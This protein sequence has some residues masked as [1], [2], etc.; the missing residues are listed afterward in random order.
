MGRLTD[1]A[2]ERSGLWRYS[3]CGLLLLAT[4]LNYMDRMTLA[5]LGSTIRA[6]Y[7]LSHANYGGLEEGFGYAFAAG[8]LFFGFL[9]DRL[10]VRWLYPSVLLLWSMAGIATAEAP[11]IGAAIQRLLGPAFDVATDPANH[12]YLG[13]LT[14]RVALGFFE[15]GHWPCAL[16]TTQ[17]ILTRKDRSFGNSILQSGAAIGAVLTPIVIVTMLP[18]PDDSDRYPL[19]TWRLPFVAIG[20]I[21]MMWALPWLALVRGSDL[22]RSRVVP[23]PNNAPTPVAWGGRSLLLMY[24]ALV[25]TVISINLSWQFFRAWLPMFLEEGRSY[26]KQQVQW[27]TAAYYIAADAGCIGVGFLVKWLAGRGWGVHRARVF[28]FGVCAAVTALSV[29]YVFLPPGPL[30]VGLLL[31]VAAA[32]LGLFPNYYSFAQEPSRT[33]Q[34]MVS[35]SLGTIAWIA[36]SRMQKLV[37][38]NIDATRSYATGIMMAGLVPLLGLAAMLLLWPRK[39]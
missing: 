27:L 28:L 1:S 12:A 25:V 30:L 20:V 34:G 5:Q 11:A 38:G 10:S 36:S 8:A 19:G 24:L 32:S 7:G 2:G 6:E 16:I 4:M 23:E 29:A 37:G 21:G 9:A 39:K 31:V 3:V 15:A 18:S 13:F 22:D 17:V 26:S 33:H 35:G 14:C